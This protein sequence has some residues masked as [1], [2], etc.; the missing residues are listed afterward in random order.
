MKHLN[1]RERGQLFLF[2]KKKKVSC[3]VTR[4]VEPASKNKLYFLFKNI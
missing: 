2:F 1:K 3:Q 4:G